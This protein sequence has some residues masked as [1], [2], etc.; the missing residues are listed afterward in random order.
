M[1]AD[2][3]ADF[4]QL[5]ETQIT[6]ERATHAF[7]CNSKFEQGPEFEPAASVSK[8]RPFPVV[9]LGCRGGPIRIVCKHALYF[10][11]VRSGS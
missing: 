1:R 10:V 9:V 4:G 8:R 7:K 11:N 2:P 3:I 6:A 5:A